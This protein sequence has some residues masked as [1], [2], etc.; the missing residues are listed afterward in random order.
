MHRFPGRSTV[1]LSLSLVFV[2]LTTGVAHEHRA[3]HDGGEAHVERAHGGHTHVLIDEEPQ[4]RSDR[5]TVPIAAVI[6]SSPTVDLS[7]APVVTTVVPLELAPR[8]RDPPHPFGA[9]APPPP[10]V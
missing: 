1:A 6:E 4:A 3:D 2:V 8:G 9:R 7:I 5:A 10:H